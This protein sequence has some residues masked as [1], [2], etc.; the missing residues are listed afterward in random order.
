MGNLSITKKWSCIQDLRFSF[1][2]KGVPHMILASYGAHL[3]T[4][5]FFEMRLFVVYLNVSSAFMLKSTRFLNVVVGCPSAL[6]M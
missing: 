1:F 5:I 2:I 3:S 4:K 6:T